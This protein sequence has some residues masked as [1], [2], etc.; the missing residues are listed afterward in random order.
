VDE[1]LRYDG[2]VQ[3]TS[4]IVAE[5]L[6]FQGKR[7][8]PGQVVLAIL[9]A[10]NHDPEQFD[11]PDSF[12]ITR[13]SKRNLAFGHGIHYCIGAPL[14]LAEAQLAFESLLRRFPNPQAAFETPAWGQSFVLRG[15]KSLP[16]TK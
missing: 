15:L 14:A 7:M 9:G 3:M 16:V 12:D 5:E 10:A 4:R 13:F 8:E 6:A 2:P 11:Q 1:M